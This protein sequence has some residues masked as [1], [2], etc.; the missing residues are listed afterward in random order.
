MKS[1]TCHFLLLFGNNLR[2]PE[3]SEGARQLVSCDSILILSL[4]VE[5]NLAWKL[6]VQHLRSSKPAFLMK[7]HESAS[8]FLCRRCRNT[9]RL[10]PEAVVGVRPIFFHNV[11]NFRVDQV[12]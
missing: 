5:G 3:T 4:T 8:Q 9:S 10:L 1:L 11:H 7:C 2:S 12:D 6:F